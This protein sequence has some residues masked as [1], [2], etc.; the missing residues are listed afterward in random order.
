PWL[1]A[2]GKIKNQLTLNGRTIHLRHYNATCGGTLIT[3]RHVLCA[4]HCFMSPRVINDPPTHVRL[5]E[6]NLRTYGFGAQD[7]LIVDRRIG[8]YDQFTRS[9]DIIILKLDRQ[10]EFN[11]RISPACLPFNLP[12]YE[13]FR[14]RLTVVGWGFTTESSQISV[15]PMREEP[16]H[17]PLWEYQQ[18]Y[19]NVTPITNKNMCAGRGIAD[20]CMGD[21]GG[22]LNFKSS[23]GINAGRVF[24]VGIVSHGPTVCGSSTQAGVYVNVAKYEHWIRNNL[25]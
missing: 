23:R 11:D 5:G 18:Q 6:H 16:E 17:V 25:Y 9:N 1:A 4:A 13:Y 8:S 2:I 10:V 22:P 24:V 20:S 12:K 21:S 14:K 7:Y 19:R 15:E 3:N